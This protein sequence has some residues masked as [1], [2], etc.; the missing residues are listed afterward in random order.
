[1][2]VCNEGAIAIVVGNHHEIC[3]AL[4]G[5]RVHAG[6]RSP[7]ETAACLKRDRVQIHQALRVKARKSVQKPRLSGR[8]VPVSA[9]Q[10]IELVCA[11]TKTDV[12]S[13]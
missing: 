8:G 7:A 3:V 2:V 13:T 9:D 12:G 4:A 5:D 10:A 1:M 11:T 6:A